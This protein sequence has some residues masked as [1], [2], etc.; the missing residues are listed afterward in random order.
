M[1]YTIDTRSFIRSFGL[2]M[3]I[4]ASAIVLAL[5]VSWM[6]APSLAKTLVEWVTGRDFETKMLIWVVVTVVIAL[7]LRHP[8]L[9]RLQDWMLKAA[10]SVIG[11]VV[12]ATSV[13]LA[14]TFAIPDVASS[15]SASRKLAILI[16]VALAA[17]PILVLVVR[18]GRDVLHGPSAR[19]RQDRL[20]IATLVCVVILVAVSGG[21]P[22]A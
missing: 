14:W 17:A 19:L 18:H 8:A 12:G 15:A 20:V 22:W 16:A 6:G 13:L 3:L 2:A 9:V 21:N 11:G 7:G 5:M 4:G 10:L 1:T